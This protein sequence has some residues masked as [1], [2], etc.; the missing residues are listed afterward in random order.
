MNRVPRRDRGP[1]P[2]G[3]TDGSNPLDVQRR[4]ALAQLRSMDGAG[5]IVAAGLFGE[6]SD[7]LIG[8][9]FEQ[10]RVYLGAA[11]VTKQS[12]GATR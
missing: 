8:G 6:A 4:D 10:A 3:N 5:P 7:L 2:S 1:A 9:S 11:P 12:G